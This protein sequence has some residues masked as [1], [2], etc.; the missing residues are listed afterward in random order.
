MPLK[1]MIRR[2]ERLEATMQPAH[3]SEFSRQLLLRLACGRRR[4]A[5]A[6]EC[7]GLPP[8]E[9]FGRPLTIEEC[10]NRGRAQSVLGGQTTLLADRNQ[11]D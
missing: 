8:L 3:E 10:L 1:A 4:V 2:I 7:E 11:T 9:A 6:R 5:E